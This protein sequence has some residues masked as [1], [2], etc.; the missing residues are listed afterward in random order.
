MALGALALGLLPFSSCTCRETTSEPP[1]KVAAPGGFGAMVT[2]RKKLDL[3]D[4]IT[5]EVTPQA[6]DPK[7]APTP[8]AK[9]AQDTVPENFPD[10]IPIPEGSE[11]MAVQ[12]LANDARNVVFS[13][14]GEAPELF[15]MYKKSMQ[16]K[17]WGSPKQEFESK[18]QSFLTF[19]KGKTVT[20]ISVTKD[21]KTGRRVVAVM[22]YDEQP[23]PFP[24]F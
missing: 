1:S 8:P 5:G 9:I 4:R 13:T 17:G 3:P 20:N 7:G 15:K 2:P 19:Q 21:P 10:G 18:D 16:E 24:E 22:Y 6:V 11:V 14:E 23:L 12:K